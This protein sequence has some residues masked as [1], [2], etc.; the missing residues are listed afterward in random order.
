MAFLAEEFFVADFATTCYR[1][2][3]PIYTPAQLENLGALIPPQHF[4]IDPILP[5]RSKVV[6]CHGPGG[7]GKSA[8]LWGAANA[9]A[10]P[11]APD[12]LG[13]ATR[14]GLPVL[15][16]ETDMNE[17][18]LNMRW[19]GDFRAHFYC[20]VFPPFD[21]MAKDWRDVP[22]VRE[23]GDLHQKIG[24][25]AIFIDTIGK[26]HRGD[27]IKDETVAL[28]YARL[29]EWFPQTT[30]WGSYHNKKPSRDAMGAEIVTDDD[31]KGNRK[32]VDDAV[33]QLQVRRAGGTKYRSKLYH[34]KSQISEM[35]DPIDL[36]I[37]IKGQV[38]LWEDGR[39]A[40]VAG[41]YNAIAQRLGQ[42]SPAKTLNCAYMEGHKVS[43]KTAKRARAMWQEEYGIA[44][45]KPGRRAGKGH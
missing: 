29:L 31:F 14:H 38:T 4:L 37:D 44:K 41:M 2:H 40:E 33:I 6:L 20:G 42:D 18:E 1:V 12:F 17:V 32:W 36:Y 11:A 3:M 35:L 19:G 15:V 9:I 28:V 43:E 22:A 8:L 27:P 34:L 21:I 10:N 7:V 5:E 24:F 13:L 23:C 45:L 30:V 26:I 16:I 25:R 39:A